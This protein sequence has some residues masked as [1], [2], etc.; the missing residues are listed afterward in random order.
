[1]TRKPSKP[2]PGGKAPSASVPPSKKV[3]ASEAGTSTA[4]TKARLG[5]GG[6]NPASTD[7]LFAKLGAAA[8]MTHE[9]IAKALFID[10]KTL[11]QYFAEEL[12]DGAHKAHLQVVG[13]LFRI[14]TQTQDNKAALT[15]AIWWTKARLGWRGDNGPPIE[16]SVDAPA[17]AGP[18]RFTLKIGER[19]DASDE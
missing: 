18:V 16:A 11:R 4:F 10:E 19:T 1:V 8:G 15:A 17:G 3:A 7:R 14:A 5:P 13:N 6:Y 2:K 9:Q 12:H